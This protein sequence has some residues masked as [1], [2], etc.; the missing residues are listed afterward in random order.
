MSSARLD[1]VTRAVSSIC[2]QGARTPEFHPGKEKLGRGTDGE[3]GSL[4]MDLSSHCV[5]TGLRP[6]GEVPK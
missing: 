5:H 1:E 2:R 3:R 4:G 6:F